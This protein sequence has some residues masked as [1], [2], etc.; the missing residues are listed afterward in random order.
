M[1]AGLS[2]LRWKI[3][4]FWNVWHVVEE[5]CFSRLIP[6]LWSGLMLCCLAQVFRDGIRNE[7]LGFPVF[8]LQLVDIFWLGNRMSVFRLGF[9]ASRLCWHISVFW[10]NCWANM[11]LFGKFCLGSWPNTLLNGWTAWVCSVFWPVFPGWSALFPFLPFLENF[12]IFLLSSNSS[13]D[14]EPYDE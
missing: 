5:L 9:P 11:F 8:C 13:G 10:P 7:F 1:L 4:V 12:K 3:S 6:L 2:L 14:V